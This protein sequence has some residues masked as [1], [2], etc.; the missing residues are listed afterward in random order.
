MW[1]EPR[2]ENEIWHPEGGKFLE[3]TLNQVIMELSKQRLHATTVTSVSFR[4]SL[5]DG[6]DGSQPWWKMQRDDELGFGMMKK[7]FISQISVW[8]TEKSVR[9]LL[10]GMEIEPQCD[11]PADKGAIQD[12][13][14]ITF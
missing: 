13:F 14:N 2:I 5:S 12:S 6:D 7:R 1:R 3:K 8:L 4:L 9:P 10:L 11:V